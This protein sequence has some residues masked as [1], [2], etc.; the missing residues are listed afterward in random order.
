MKLLNII[1]TRVNR[2]PNYS[3]IWKVNVWEVNHYICIIKYMNKLWCITY[4]YISIY[5]N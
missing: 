2:L 1:Y 3:D 4:I 5:L